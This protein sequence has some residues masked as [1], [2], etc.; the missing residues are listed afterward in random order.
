ME[1]STSSRLFADAQEVLVGGVNSPVRAF[2]GVGGEP[3]F[4]VS[5]DGAWV[6]DSDGNRYV[7][8]VLSWGPLIM[9][10]AHPAVVEAVQAAMAKGSSFGMPTE[11]ETMLARKIIQHVPSIEKVRLVNSGTEAA[12]SAIRLAR[13]YTGRD[14]VVKMEGCYHGHADGLLVK[15]GSGLTTLGVPTSPG[16]PDAYAACTLTIPYNDLA[17]AE[18][19]FAQRGAEI[20]CLAL[21]PLPGNMGVVLPE[22]GYLE[23]LRELTRKHGALLLFDEVVTGFRLAYRGAQEYYGVIPDLVAYGKALGGGYPIGAFGGRADIMDIVTESRMN[24]DT[25]VWVAS[26]LGGNPICTAAA[27]A[28]LGIF[29]QPGTYPHLH[30]L[31][32][33]FRNELRCA[34]DDHGITAQVIGDGPLAQV[35]FAAHDIVDYRTAH[36]ADRTR[37]RKLMLELFGRGIFLNPMGT[38]LYLSL[39]HTED[40]CDEFRNRFEDALRNIGE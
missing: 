13:G 32:S 38:K 15:A 34:L 6:T 36:A 16:V 24:D 4:A 22:P 1:R 33:Y 12:M 40:T 21:E 37:G 7:D 5:G 39:A 2:N 31:G 9:G 11:A 27:L 23:G 35:L 30:E 19:V 17:A 8:Y 20:A 18:E 10:H 3:V 14:L 26:T 29:R 28:A 25:Y